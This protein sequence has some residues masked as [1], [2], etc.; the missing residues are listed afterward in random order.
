MAGVRGLSLPSGAGVLP[1]PSSTCGPSPKG[2][3]QRTASYQNGI[4]DSN[5]TAMCGEVRLRRNSC[6]TALERW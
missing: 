6:Y 2:L 3:G 5:F 4:M 1:M